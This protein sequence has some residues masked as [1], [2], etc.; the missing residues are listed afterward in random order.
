MS[1]RA[2]S[3]QVY[4]YDA[5]PSI[6]DFRGV[7]EACPQCKRGQELPN[8]YAI[9]SSNAHNC[10]AFY[11][12]MFQNCRS[13]FFA[14]YFKGPASSEYVLSGTQVPN[15]VEVPDDI[16]KIINELSPD[17]I[18]IYTQ[19]H[20]AEQNGLDLIAGCGYRK[21]LEF[22]IKDYCIKLVF[23]DKNDGKITPQ[24]QKTIDSIKSAQ[25][26][27]VINNHL[28]MPKVK[29][30]AARATWLGN[31]ETHYERRIENGDIS[32]M[33]S[34]MKLVTHF[35]EAEEEAKK[36]ETEIRPASQ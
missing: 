19:A 18:R 6:R 9:A 4:S 22:L 12:C 26:G 33:K 11:Q 27:S 32:V 14:H 25:L 35:I 31:D 30:L 1:R 3:G 16:P 23:D 13:P 2:F 34:L 28:G 24:Q 5:G 29:T 10:F 21:A 7:P 17:Y 36:L 8:P 20:R 15:Y